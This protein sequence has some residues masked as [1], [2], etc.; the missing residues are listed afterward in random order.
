MLATQ[1]VKNHVASLVVALILAA[2]TFTNVKLGDLEIEYA[3]LTIMSV[4]IV[5]IVM[6]H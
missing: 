6:S 3:Q 2:G 4:Q 5:M 1:M